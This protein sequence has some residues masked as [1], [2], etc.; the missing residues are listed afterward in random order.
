METGKHAEQTEIWVWHLREFGARDTY[1]N[2]K[3]IKAVCEAC[4]R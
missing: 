1:L 3:Y 4:S 2:I